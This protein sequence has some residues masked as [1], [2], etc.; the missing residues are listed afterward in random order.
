[1]TC[2]SIVHKQMEHGIIVRPTASCSSSANSLIAP[3]TRSFTTN[4]SRYSESEFRNASEQLMMLSALP[5]VFSR[6]RSLAFRYDTD[7]RSLRNLQ[8]EVGSWDVGWMYQYGASGL[9]IGNRGLTTAFA[10]NAIDGHYT[11]T[12]KRGLSMVTKG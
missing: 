6:V 9:R 7:I 1:V 3:I 5:C 10:V 11:E 2:S 12:L 8:C 4:W